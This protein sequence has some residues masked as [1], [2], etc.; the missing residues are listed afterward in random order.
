VA[1]VLLNL[2]DAALAAGDPGVALAYYD[3]AAATLS[4]VYGP[5]HPDVARALAD[6]GRV[7]LDTG[8]PAEARARFA[9]CLA[10]DEAAF[11]A[12]HPTVAQRRAELAAAVKALALTGPPATTPA[13]ARAAPVVDDDGPIPL[14]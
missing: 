9:R 7:L 14:E 10:I 11:G 8:R 12:I 6:A 1:A 5:D 3:R 13:A 2:G 4:A